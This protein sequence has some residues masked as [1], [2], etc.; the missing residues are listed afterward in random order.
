MQP[1]VEVRDLSVSFGDR[2]ITH[3]VSFTLHPG[4][5]T[6]LVGESG[7]GKTVSAMALPSLDPSVATVRGEARLFLEQPKEETYEPAVLPSCQ[8]A[9]VQTLQESSVAASNLENRHHYDEYSRRHYINLLADK[10][11]LQKVRG[12]YIGTIF[13]EPATAFD[14]V[15]T[16]GYQIREALQCHGRYSRRELRQRVLDQLREVGL[17]DALRIYRS[18][19]HELSGGQLQRAMIAMAIINRP[20]VLIADEPT[21][22]LDVTTQQGILELMGE[23]AQELSLAVL[24]ITHDM[25]VVWQCADDVYVM[26]DG[27]LIEHG[28]V[29]EVFAHPRER[30]TK[31]LLQAVPRLHFQEINRDHQVS[32]SAQDGNNEIC[33]NTE[34]CDST[35]QH[36]SQSVVA[37]LEHVSVQYP[38]RSSYAIHDVNLTL[39]A[40]QTCA[41]VGESGAGK[42][43][44]AKALS[45]QLR[46]IEGV[47][48]LNGNNLAKL[49]GAERRASLSQ[50]GY[51]FQ[52]SGSALN[53]RKKVGWSIAEPLIIHGGYSQSQRKQRVEDLLRH[54]QLDPQLAER[55]PHQLSGGQRQRVG[56]ARALAL[57]PSLLIADEP[58]SSLDVTV[59]ALVLD[60]FERLQDEYHF[61]CLFITHDFGVVEQVA[62]TVA[63]LE[64]GKIVEQGTAQQVLM[65]PQHEYTKT[66]LAASP[67]IEFSV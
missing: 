13:Q 16:V 65:H 63:V 6:A 27:R 52:D 17:E 8:S 15:F 12:G 48:N 5:I 1:I 25:A 3:K 64:S 34:A 20:K 4:K 58:T 38:K 32:L 43:T 61:A 24:L 42:S 7:S 59:Q 55:Y 47:V 54:V 49:K 41:L 29:Q 2:D 67:R 36:G 18:Y 21:T 50:L 62:D 19:P 10:S 40:G 57:N 9:I 23:L 56:I 35:D 44:I 45:G 60:L 39:Y 26:Y 46:D 28:S 22:A 11:Q 14:P 66:L 31:R 51:V 37:K 33:N 30:Y 53:P